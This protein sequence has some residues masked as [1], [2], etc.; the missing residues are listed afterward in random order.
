MIFD[1]QKIEDLT[2]QGRLSQAA[3]LLTL[4][5]AENPSLG[6]RVRTLHA[7]V[8]AIAGDDH[9]LAR[10][11]EPQL[12]ECRTG[13]AVA[14]YYTANGIEPQGYDHLV[15]GVVLAA[16]GNASAA[17][18]SLRESHD[19]ALAERKIHL[20]VAA[21]ER[22]AHHALLFGDPK[23]AR[24]AIEEAIALAGARRISAWLLRALAAGA[25]FA[26]ESGDLERT[27]QL[28]ARANAE[29]R[30]EAIALFAPI[31]AQLAVELGD[32][33]ALR[34][35][36]SPALLE[37]A[38]RSESPELTIAATIAALLGA[39]AASRDVHSPAL[40]RALLQADGAANVPELFLM[41]ARYGDLDEARLGVEALAAAY[42]P[43]RP[44][45][46]AHQLLAR[47]HLFLRTGDRAASIDCAG[48]AARAFSAMG[49][50]RW[51][52]DAMML[53]VAHEPPAD[54]RA[55]GR[56]TG[57]AL[58]EREQQVANLIRRGARNR[59]VAVALQISEHT[60]ERHVSSILGRLGL[61]SR[62]Q[63]AEP[64]RN[65]EH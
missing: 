26:L 12:L 27:A 64:R 61:R 56:S 55:R 7:A 17:Y 31:G 16:A 58:T 37:A 50:R 32:D 10:V 8:Y 14:R 29:T 2:A 39:G 62:W 5:R 33:G 44:Y 38:M 34:T 51:T 47:A 60:V 63:I 23:L 3:A 49:L 57:S 19:R 41:A 40:R 54:R 13:D 35:W 65:D 43:N 22:L 9:G 11:V 30:S 48:D 18:D 52:N 15:A 53:L 1:N 45:L 20:A 36:T 21:R 42:S 25:R 24:S 4:V 59:E 28:L 46:R 6:A